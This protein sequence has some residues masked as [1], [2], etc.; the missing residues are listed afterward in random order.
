MSPA[1]TMGGAVTA[2]GI[3]RVDIDRGRR[4]CHVVWHNDERGPTA[5]AK[6]SLGTGLVYTYT[7]DPDPN[8]V[9]AWYLSAIDFRSGATVYRQLAGTDFYYNNN[10]APITIGPDGTAYVGVLGGLALLR[11]GS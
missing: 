7:K 3:E 6:L 2:P 5:V 4:S 9:G 8:G 1:D 11:D 10:Y